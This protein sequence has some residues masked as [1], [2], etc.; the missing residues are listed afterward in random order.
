MM[1]GMKKTTLYLPDELKCEIERVSRETGK[2]EADLIRASIRDGLPR[3]LP[4]TPIGGLFDSGGQCLSERVDELL[5][6]FGEH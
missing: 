4:P 3:Q 6:G 5:R 1:Y 2:S